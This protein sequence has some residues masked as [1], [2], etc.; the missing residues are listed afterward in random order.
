VQTARTF[1]LT[2]CAVFF[3]QGSLVQL[4]VALVLSV[5]FLVSVMKLRPYRGTV[6]AN[7]YAV[8]VNSL[9]VAVLFM[10]LLLEVNSRSKRGPMMRKRN[11]HVLTHPY[12]VAPLDFGI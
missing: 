5:L 9:M 3:A 4:A 10:A 11:L 8:L 12:R 6:F 1:I 7:E 2:G